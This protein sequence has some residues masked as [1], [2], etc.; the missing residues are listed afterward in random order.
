MRCHSIDKQNYNEEGKVSSFSAQI[1]ST[2]Y[3]S[4]HFGWF[5]I[6]FNELLR[7]CL[8]SNPICS[9]AHLLS[10]L[11]WIAIIYVMCGMIYVYISSLTPDVQSIPFQKSPELISKQSKSFLKPSLKSSQ[12]SHFKTVSQ[13]HKLWWI[14]G[15]RLM[16]WWW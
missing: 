3:M 14:C 9:F 2:P 1:P 16:K 4:C 8:V 10:S 13:T 12:V 5:V 15:L 6:K 7:N 11:F